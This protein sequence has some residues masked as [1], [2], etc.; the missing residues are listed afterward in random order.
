M[1]KL[2]MIVATIL[3]GTSVYAEETPKTAEESVTEET[4]VSAFENWNF[5]VALEERISSDRS[6]QTLLKLQTDTAVTDKISFFAAIWLRD[7]LPFYVDEEK[8]HHKIGDS[9]Y[10]N[11]VDMFAGLSY[12]LHQYFNPYAF[13][14]VYYDRP[15]IDN[16]WGGFASLGFS[17]TLYNE[18]KHNLSY[19][20]EW[21]MT[22]NTYDLDDF[23][24]WGTESAVK[25]K[26][27][28]YDKTGLYVQG[29]WNTEDTDYSDGTYST[30][31]GIQVDF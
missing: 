11:Y 9:D 6:S 21:Y 5:N 22:L 28:I 18:E 17:G 4:T 29:V 13:Y 27:N 30:R 3:L 15:E 24:L 12:S 16:Q 14:E 8:H 23:E 1:T 31:I 2:S 19:Y 25:Y 20:T 26:Y 7:Q 10:I